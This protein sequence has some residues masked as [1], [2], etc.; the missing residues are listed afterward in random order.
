MVLAFLF[1]IRRSI[2]YPSHWQAFFQAS[3][4]KNWNI[5]IHQ[6]ENGNLGWFNRF[7]LPRHLVVPTKHGHISLVQASNQLLNRAF[8]Q[9]NNTHFILLSESCLPLKSLQYILSY[10]NPSFSYFSDYEGYRDRCQS[11]LTFLSQSQIRTASQW[12][13]LNRQAVYSILHHPEYLTYFQHVC[14][15]DEHIYATILHNHRSKQMIRYGWTTYC[16]WNVPPL[17]RGFLLDEDQEFCRPIH[18]VLLDQSFLISLQ[19]HPQQLFM[20]KIHPN[21]MIQYDQ[22]DSYPGDNADV[23]L[24]RQHNNPDDLAAA[25]KHCQDKNYGGFVWHQ[26]TFYFRRQTAAELIEHRQPN[27]ESTL[28]LGGDFPK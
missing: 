17:F 20:R 10:L 11:A 3:H 15:A 8:K 6:K 16:Q 7:K 22:H 18:Y 2:N 25:K 19:Q 9:P 12:C 28:I 14:A 13:I 1:L 26:Q 5:Y 24:N 4:C 23:W 21:C 27:P